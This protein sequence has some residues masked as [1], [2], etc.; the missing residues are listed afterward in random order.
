M[1][2]VALVGH[3]Q[4]VLA[5]GLHTVSRDDRQHF[6]DDT[7]WFSL[8]LCGANNKQVEQHFADAYGLR[9]TI[10][11]TSS[12][13]RLHV[14]RSPPHLRCGRSRKVVPHLYCPMW[15]AKHWSAA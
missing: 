1:F 10:H 12:K 3:C 13:Q 14:R 9:E 11:A 6:D 2:A 4:S 8:R 15:R 7:L 5:R